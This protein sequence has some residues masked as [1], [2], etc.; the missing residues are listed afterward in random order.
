[1]HSKG[2]LSDIL[3]IVGYIIIF[4]LLVVFEVMKRS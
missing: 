4:P 3:F 2:L 1:M